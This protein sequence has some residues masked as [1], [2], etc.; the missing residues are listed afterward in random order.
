MQLNQYLSIKKKCRI[1]LPDSCVL[2]GVVDPTGTLEENEIFIQI[3]KDS[4][5]VHRHGYGAKKREKRMEEA[6]A[7]SSIDS[8]H[9]VIE[10]DV[11][12]TRNP[13]THPGD[14]R[15]LKCVDNPRLK[16]MFNVI[17]FSQKGERPQCNMM[18]GGDL[19]GDVYFIT[20]D[21]E[22]VSYV[23]PENI[24]P[25]A[26]Y[27]KSQLI[28]EK[29][30]SDD[31]ADYFCFYLE[32]DVLGTVSNLWLTL[33]DYYGE[34]GPCNENCLALSQMCSVAVDFAK[35]GECVS[36]KNFSPLTKIVKS[37][38]DFLEKEGKPMIQSQGVLGQLYRDI[39]NDF[40]LDAMVENDR[41]MSICL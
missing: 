26:D 18:S 19:D 38:P 36:R 10:G 39:K 9:K 4:F 34:K 3:R 8:I 14:I 17:I 20:W 5:S 21:K 11:L 32:R 35:H 40:A 27:S 12:V 28:K 22:L 7:V 13:C 2:M 29:P 15:R 30:E 25:P 1:L 41:K 37:Y 23:K 31:I 24:H 33:C 16:E 6:E